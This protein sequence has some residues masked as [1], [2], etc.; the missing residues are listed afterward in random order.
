MKLRS[1]R[2]NQKVILIVVA[3]V[4]AIAIIA[5]VVI[6]LSLKKQEEQ[7]A[8]EEK[9]VTKITITSMPDT[10]YY[11]GEEANWSG[12]QI[13]AV[14]TSMDTTYFI[15]YPSHEL[16]ITG[17][18]SETAGEK[19]IT[20]QYQEFTTTF[21]VTVKE[22]STPAPT[23]VA[24]EVCDMPTSYSRTDWNEG[25][26]IIKSAY[27][28]LTYSDGTVIGSYAET[29]LLYSYIEPYDT[30]ENGEN[31]TYLT[32]T[33]IEGGIAVSTTVTITITE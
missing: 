31:V 25:G 27:L 14:T 18:D 1:K 12:L 9:V 26:P 21:V 3:I 19:V 7:K 29:P 11:I 17:F 4:A 30:V 22:Y 20:V 24:V 13:Q 6:G 33:Y 5:G 8:E 10:E 2:S 23:V 16:T 28:K 32:I 15:N